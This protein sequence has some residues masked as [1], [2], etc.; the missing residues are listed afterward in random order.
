[1]KQFTFK[2]AAI[3]DDDV[4]SVGMQSFHFTNIE[5]F[6]N[7]EYAQ[8]EKLQRPRMIATSC[9]DVLDEFFMSNDRRI[10][11]GEVEGRIEIIP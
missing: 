2:G 5:D 7:V 9:V 10:F 11:T 6:L 3:G 1:M 8:L 4:F